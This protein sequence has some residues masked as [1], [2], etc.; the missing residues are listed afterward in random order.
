[1]L[2]LIARRAL[3]SLATLLIA[4]LL[5][6]TLFDALPGDIGSTRLS[7]FSDPIAAVYIR[8]ERGLYRGFFV[9]YLEW[10]SYVVNG[11]LGRSWGNGREI[12]ELLKSRF[13]NT[14]MLALAATV[15][16]VPIAVSLGILS[17]IRRD[18]WL[19]RI[20]QAGTLGLFSIPEFALGYCIVFLLAIYFPLFP[21]ISIVADSTPTNEYLRSLALPALTLSLVML[22]QIARP[23]RAA[24]L[25]I[26]TR[27]FIEMAILKGLK[28]WRIFLLHALPHALGPI[29]NAVILAI[30][31][32]ITGTLIVEYVF[33]FPGVGQFFIDAVQ[34]QDI[35]VVLTCGLFFTAIYVGLIWLA[36]VVAILGNP[37]LAVSELQQQRPW[38]IRPLRL[39]PALRVGVT[40]AGVV[41][42]LAVIAPGLKQY[43]VET[44][45]MPALEIYP[46]AG[47][48][49]LIRADDLHT[50]EYQ[51]VGPVHN[52]YFMPVG[53]S[54][55]AQHELRGVLQLDSAAIIGSRVFST[56]MRGLGE[57]PPFEFGL[58]TH[59]GQLVPLRR[60]LII[61]GDEPLA[62]AFGVGKVWSEPGD[63]GYS[64]ASFLFTL[65]P[66]LRGQTF[67]GLG[68]FLFNDKNVSSARFQLVQE[69]APTTRF[70]AWGQIEARYEPGELDHHLVTRALKALE[71]RSAV[72]PWSELEKAFDPS[73]LREIEGSGI[74]ENMTT[75][76]LLIDG[77]LYTLPCKT[78]FGNYPFCRELRH[79]V[80]SV[81]KSIGAL[82]SMLRLAQKYGDEVFDERIL[83]YLPINASHDGWERVTF[84]DT[85]N[86]ATG[87]GEDEPRRVSS[88]VDEDYS[89]E[90]A[91]IGEVLSTKRK[92]ERI[93]ELGNY[94]WG[95]GEVF[96]YRTF[97]TFVVTAAMDRYL[98]HREGADANLWQM[99]SREVLEPLNIF[100]MPMQTS[101]ERDSRDELPLY[102][103]A[104][105]P[106]LDEL[107]RIATLL[108]N[109]GVHDGVQLLS[110]T[111]LSEA[112]GRNFHVGLPTGWRYD[113]G[114]IVT[115]HMSLWQTR[116]SSRSGCVVSVPHMSGYGGNYVVMMPN[117]VT[118]FR[119]ADGRD[120]E[121]G[122]WDSESL[123]RVADYVR[124]LSCD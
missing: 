49:D 109:G 122:T 102:G 53:D 57:L 44:T 65:A 108:Q 62:V 56:T 28:T 55:P 93:A 77:K 45:I 100:D 110:P 17:A 16:G 117:G 8:E 114:Q 18:T 85:L 118:A 83:D 29:C 6:F 81:F 43:R 25:N 92:L 12:S 76:A 61:S 73:E 116:F 46:P 36:D 112:V 99:L 66:R 71:S 69:S 72:L 33:A 75:G 37:R 121:R 3:I 67:N 123:R 15:L 68:T 39:T 40:A 95:P 51:G 86:M 87:I 4:T 58:F 1:M 50:E 52:D 80:Y 38:K 35:P 94:E 104:M 107:S 22:A 105:L 5:V 2:T 26:L 89:E 19:D 23:T 82:V 78:R 47:S 54:G 13:F 115:Y 60:D 10:V 97:D 119:L 84:G 11:E 27:P 124:P 103:Y 30:A 88:D 20:V 70:D 120:G 24:V 34:I 14:G 113:D 9:R 91:Y 7:R 59:R 101:I 32:L 90:A 96:R 64:R 41:V 31:N 63:A 48:R 98:K 74:T 106:T 42:V 111:K 21:S 79:G